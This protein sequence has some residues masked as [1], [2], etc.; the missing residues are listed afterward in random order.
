[1]AAFMG[2]SSTQRFLTIVDWVTF[3]RR[4]SPAHPDLRPWK[5]VEIMRVSNGNPLMTVTT[6]CLAIVSTFRASEGAGTIQRLAVPWL[7]GSTGQAGD[8]NRKCTTRFT[9][10]HRPTWL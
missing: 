6:T 5:R 7:L 2:G 4:T 1:R 9:E 8:G 10:S 3:R